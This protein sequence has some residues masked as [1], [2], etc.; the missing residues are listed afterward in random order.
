MTRLFPIGIV[1]FALLTSC[2]FVGEPPTTADATPPPGYAPIFLKRSAPMP[3][4]KPVNACVQISGVDTRNPA[5]TRL[6]MH[7]V[8]SS[9]TLY[10]QSDIVKFKK[11]ICR[12]VEVIDGDSI[13]VSNL[14]VTQLT[15]ADPQPLSIALVMDNSGSMGEQR[16]LAVQDAATVL[17]DKKGATDALAFVRY[18]DKVNVEVPL[19]TSAEAL[20]TGLKHDGLFGY[21]GGTAILTGTEQ[22]IRHLASTAPTNSRRAVIVFTDGQENSSTITKEQ[23]VEVSLQERTP[24]Y[25][26]DFGDGI[27]A[28]YMED[29]SQA[30]GGFYQHIYRTS[31]FD[32]L[33]EDAYRRLRNVFVIEYPTLGY[34]NHIASVTLCWGSDTVRAQTEYNNLPEVGRI[35]LLDVYFDTGKA[36]LK[37][38][39][40]RA[41]SNVTNLMKAMPTMTIELRGH[42]D[43]TNNTGDPEFNTTLSQ[44]RA[45]AVKTALVKNGIEDSRI[46]A[47]G[48]GDTVPVAP[49]S[50]PEGRA[51]NRRTEFVVRSR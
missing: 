31:E 42:T 35:A 14:T 46:T 49:N 34:G 32:D 25:A 39:S 5:T 9:G 15:E 48:F 26:V 8:D 47:K 13:P 18:D 30:T 11:M 51:R 10:T 3:P 43:S 33:F 27:N 37:P 38:E 44:Q 21:G 22:A 40:K 23:L 4:T 6:F 41:I 50:T 29:L 28:G 24:I 19:T 36:T 2:S 45:D 20:R 7:V 1:L 16:A 12:V 17:I